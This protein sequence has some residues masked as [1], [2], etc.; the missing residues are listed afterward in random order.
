MKYALMLKDLFSSFFEVLNFL[1]CVI[2]ALFS[3]AAVTPLTL[4]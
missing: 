2:C 3:W 4:T 1:L